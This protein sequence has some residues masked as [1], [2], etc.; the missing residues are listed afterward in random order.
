MV[1]ISGVLVGLIF[2]AA[3]AGLIFVNDLGSAESQSVINSEL[4]ETPQDD[5][6]K[7]LNDFDSILVSF[8]SDVKE[9]LGFL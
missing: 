6:V 3:V 5:I 2:V 9:D 8:I 1:E 4:I 7:A